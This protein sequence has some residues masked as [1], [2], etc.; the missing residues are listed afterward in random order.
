LPEVARTLLRRVGLLFSVDIAF[1][2]DIGAMVYLLRRDERLE[3][4]NGEAEAK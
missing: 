4:S 1:G 3:K 2:S